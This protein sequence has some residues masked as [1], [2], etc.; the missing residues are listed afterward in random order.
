MTTH[1]P[2]GCAIDRHWLM[3]RALSSRCYTI[4]HHQQTHTCHQKLLLQ[5]TSMEPSTTTSFFHPKRSQFATD[6]KQDR[7]NTRGRVGNTSQLEERRLHECVRLYKRT[8]TPYRPT[9]NLAH[10]KCASP[11]RALHLSARAHRLSRCTHAR[12]RVMLTQE[13]SVPLLVTPP[14]KKATQ[15]L[16]LFCAN[17]TPPLSLNFHNISGMLK[18]RVPP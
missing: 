15:Q 5:P 6:G 17:L 9:S 12:M 10:W 11:L 4:Y 14:S 3:I 1:E 2:F 18:I 8:R 7:K 16:S 13:S